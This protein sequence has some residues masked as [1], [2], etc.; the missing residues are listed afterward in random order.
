LV[1]IFVE[2]MNAI[3][4]SSPSLIQA[5]VSVCGY[6]LT[7]IIEAVPFLIQM[8]IWYY[9][10]LF[11]VLE[12][13]LNLLASMARAFRA[14]SPNRKRSEV[15]NPTGG[16][17][18]L[19][20]EWNVDYDY[21]RMP[22]YVGDTAE[23]TDQYWTEDS[24][25]WNS[26]QLNDMNVW[27]IKNPP[28][29]HSYY[30]YLDQPTLDDMPE[31]Q[32]A[33]MSP[34]ML[35]LH[36][37]PF[38]VEHDTVLHDYTDDSSRYSMPLN[39]RQS[40]SIRITRSSDGRPPPTS[41]SV[42]S[43]RGNYTHRTHQHTAAP[44]TTLRGGLLNHRPLPPLHHDFHKKVMC[45]SK[46]CG[47]Y[48]KALPHPL[49]AIKADRSYKGHMFG[50]NKETQEEHKQRFVHTSAAIHATRRA[51]HEVF[52]E[53][54]HGNNGR[55]EQH[56]RNLLHT[57]TGF[58]TSSELF[59]HVTSHHEHPADSMLSYV[60]VLSELPVFRWMRDFD[61]RYDQ[62][63]GNWMRQRSV[64]MFNQTAGHE[65]I[66]N[67]AA[68]RRHLL[69]YSPSA[70]GSASA[71][72]LFVTP[73][74]STVQDTKN[75]VKDPNTAPSLPV[76]KLL[77]TTD[78]LRKPGV[79]QPLNPLCL[80]EIPQQLICFVENVIYKFSSE[81][82]AN[83][84]F[85]DYEPQC[86][87]IGF[88]IIQRPAFSFNLLI[89]VDNLEYWINWCWIQNGLVYTSLIVTLVFPAW[90]TFLKIIGS[91]FPAI[92]G[93][94]D[95]IY[96]LTPNSPLKFNDIVC[97]MIFAY[98]PVIC[99][100]LLFAIY[101]I[102]YPLYLFLWR[103][104]ETLESLYSACVA[105]MASQWAATEEAEWYQKQELSFILNARKVLRRDPFFVRPKR[106]GPI[107][108]PD[109]ETPSVDELVKP[110][111]YSRV[112]N[113]GAR[114]P[115]SASMISSHVQMLQAER[116]AQTQGGPLMVGG[117]LPGFEDGDRDVEMAA[118]LT[119]DYQGDPNDALDQFVSPEQDAITPEIR[120]SMISLVRSLQE[121]RNF[122]GE[123][124]PTVT[125]DEA[126][127]F[128][129]R[130]KPLILSL[131]YSNHW[132]SRYINEHLHTLHKYTHRK[133]VETQHWDGMLQSHQ[134]QMEQ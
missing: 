43:S 13:I 33:Y 100:V 38:T 39:E 62:F 23:A 102:L 93:L 44:R 72:I 25:E 97:F 52:K 26:Q 107:V 114:I 113:N 83:L 132:V 61:E 65:Y 104:I 54:Y 27:N 35:T 63:Y 124:D 31:F 92:A 130:F 78:C 41:S 71:P 12:P 103:C 101:V 123:P 22:Q 74:K 7:M 15:P 70:V 46:L 133:P 129:Q 6:C 119:P 28:G 89:I 3:V 17:T 11:F 116:R 73:E 68:S 84:Q 69:Q 2:I 42:A 80:P 45:K 56:V 49:I 4:S 105:I 117:S 59:A 90:K 127:A 60:P 37:D 79:N 86:A 64:F 82:I 91:Q 32:H 95:L 14:G 99:A 47:G 34:E 58:R 77:S 121:A 10:I 96:E 29:T 88:C 1:E 24:L 112:Q 125:M 126:L 110:L 19:N 48:G 51:V 40:R 98:A 122:F 36:R 9:R 76:F 115:I 16:S 8:Y 108:D 106:R 85:C 5:L 66:Q 120:Q 75:H 94:T 131:H 20:P 57:V 50:I 55:T 67:T 134:A 21:E 53:H 109:D 111:V 18:G 87:N 128:E 81:K 118:E 30:H